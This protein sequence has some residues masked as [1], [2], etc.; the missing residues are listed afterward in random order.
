MWSKQ[1]KTLIGLNVTTLFHD[2]NYNKTIKK[3]PIH[4]ITSR[5]DE[6]KRNNLLIC[7]KPGPLEI[8]WICSSD[9]DSDTKQEKSTPSNATYMSFDDIEASLP[10]QPNLTQSEIDE[11]DQ[12]MMDD[13]LRGYDES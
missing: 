11:L 1:S 3:Y 13:C 4:S 5:N 10:N 8:D 12:Q 9:S 2:H 6:L 7:H